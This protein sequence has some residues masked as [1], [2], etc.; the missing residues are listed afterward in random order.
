MDNILFFRV[1]T[2]EILISPIYFYFLLFFS[3]PFFPSLP[4][5][6]PHNTPEQSCEILGYLTMGHLSRQRDKV[7]R[8]L[9]EPHFVVLDAKYI[10]ARR[11][12]ECP[13]VAFFRS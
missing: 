6:F 5:F 10:A 13:L 7:I 4:H 11:L 1:F 2:I 9:R 8:F 12:Y 3:F